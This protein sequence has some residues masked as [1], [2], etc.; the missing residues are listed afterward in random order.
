ML[1]KV[2]ATKLDRFK[3]I[4]NDGIAPDTVTY[5]KCLWDSL[6]DMYIK[7]GLIMESYADY[8]LEKQVFY[9]LEQMQVEEFCLICLLLESLFWRRL[10]N[11]RRG[12][13]W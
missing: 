7:C 5:P 13:T 4:Q 2:K 10:S 1:N 12:I 11:K 9:C 8:A 3:Q 6:I